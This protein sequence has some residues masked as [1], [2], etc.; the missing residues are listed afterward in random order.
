MPT[1]TSSSNRRLPKLAWGT[2]L[3]T[4]LVAT[5]LL[6]A[7]MELRLAL[8]GYQPT[9]VDGPDLW[10]HERQRAAALGSRALILVGA[11]RVQLDLDLGV[12]R[13]AT[14]LEPVQ[15]GIDGSDFQPVLADL[16]AD[17]RIRGTVVVD[18]AE[19]VMAGSF[20]GVAA[21]WVA[22]AAA[23]DHG[24]RLPGFQDAEDALMRFVR[25]HL[26]SYAGGT[27]PITSLLDRLL[28]VQPTPQYVIT[29]AD[30][31]QWADYSRLPMPWFYYRRVMRNLGQEIPLRH[32][33]AA[34]DLEDELRR[35]V[36]ALTPGIRGLQ[37]YEAS[38]RMLA[39]QAAAI[40][41][42]GGQVYFVMLPSSGLVREMERRR[43][44]RA[45]FW[46]RF[47][48]LVGAPTLHFEDVP[49]MRDIVCPDG[50]HLDYRQRAAFT[51]A[52]VEALGIARGR[53]P[54]DL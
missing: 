23:H 51:A 9:V 52:L 4:A 10:R 41:A 54:K 16:A 27:R 38:S 28:P 18:V 24:A 37:R 3:G 32:G 42:R 44:P 29:S 2:V 12:L 20:P 13:R 14:G 40:R 17:P 36:A 22:R 21:D 11:S 5:V 45:Q 34:Q 35:R 53:M 30:R 1:F 31:S 15:L 8:R 19:H 39:A 50:S 48:A 7:T 43:F 26:R 25:S 46:D 6:A 33:M 49:A 47:V